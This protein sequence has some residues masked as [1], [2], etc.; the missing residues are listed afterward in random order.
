MLWPMC[1]RLRQIWEIHTFWRSGKSHALG[2][3]A[4]TEAT[5]VLR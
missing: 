2:L 1:G 4:L 3:L 5:T